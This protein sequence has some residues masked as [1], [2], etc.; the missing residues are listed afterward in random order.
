MPHPIEA[1]SL[2]EFETLLDAWTPVRRITQVHVHC[3]DHPR[4]AEFRGLASV[5]AMR[6][7]HQSIGM[8]DIAQH[9]TID[10]QGLIWTGRPFDVMPASVRGHNGTTAAGPFM[11]EMVGLFERKVDPFAGAQKNTA[12]AVVRAVLAKC[13][14][15]EN[16]VKFHREFLNTGKTCPGLDLDP[17]KFRTDIKA[18]LAN[19]T[20]SAF[21]VP[22]P[23]GLT[24]GAIV[25]TALTRSDLRPE[26]DYL[27][28]PEHAHAAEEQAV[29]TR[30]IEQGRLATDDGAGARGIEDEFRDLIG[31]AVNTSQGVLSG[32]G[33][34]QNTTADLDTLVRDHLTPQFDGD[35]FDHLLFYAHGGLVGETSAL[36]YARA[37]LP[38]WKSHRVY[39]IF[40]IW[41]SS[42]FQTIWKQPRGQRGLGD[43]WDKGVEVATQQLARPIWAEMKANARRCSEP[44]TRFGRP[45][46]LHELAQ[47]L[48]P[49]LSQHKKVKLHAVGH[50]TGPIVLAPFMRLF[51]DE[52]LAFESLNYLAP[53]IRIDDY[54][55][56]V[57]PIVDG[58]TV[59]RLRVFTMSDKAER[60]DN[61]A[62]IYRKSLLYYVR[63]ACEDRNDGR[64]LGLQKDLFADPSMRSAFGLADKRDLRAP[65]KYSVS[66]VRAIEF[67]QRD[68]D[69]A[70][71]QRTLATQHGGFDNDE[72]TL[73]SVL[74][75]VLGVA[76]LGFGG[77]RF[78]TS[79]DFARTLEGAD[80]A[81]AL[82]QP[83][84][85]EAQPSVDCVCCCCHGE[86]AKP[87][88]AFDR[89]DDGE[90]EPVDSG[91]Q[92][93]VDRAESPVTR[94]VAVCIGIDTYAGMPLSGCVNDS[95]AWQARL[96]RAGFSVTTL[97]NRD[98]TRSRMLE[99]L[100]S[101]VKD[102]RRGDQLVFQYAGHG[103]QVP[104][105]NGDE[106]DR[107]DEALVPVDYQRGE[108]LTDDDIYQVCAQLR[109]RPGVTLTFFMDCCNS[110]TNTRVAALPRPGLNQQVRF[111]KLPASVIREYE[112]VRRRDGARA[113]VP[114]AGEREPQPGVVSFAACLDH[115]FAFETDSHGD[116]TT[117]AMTVFDTTLAGGG[118]NQAFITA[119]L[120]AFGRDRRQNPTLLDPAP[121]MKQRRFLGG[122]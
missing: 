16:A 80:A 60:D 79:E 119:I 10:P 114:P 49:W 95:R 94:R 97:R 106:V 89:E 28:V 24:R 87:V 4:H 14:L 116:F 55:R 18:L 86:K 92:A 42:L 27:E 8:A 6:A 1:L 9:L 17:A 69:G 34:M 98:A 3:T 104:D 50:S 61:V 52:G 56:D 117:S 120:K 33:A 88:T 5:E 12:Y 75:N 25:R 115:E 93:S 101:L 31:H 76:A 32:K 84:D 21:D 122:R 83:D 63:D 99:A 13:G 11:V 110:G 39:P 26:P 41:E 23:S 102:S 58:R 48:L 103:T 2:S 59:K 7:F 100:T 109:E 29:L 113:T 85:G 22:V 73:R 78:P 112:A 74:A 35:G 30:L 47:R 20:L 57:A 44:T 118:S 37:M 15:D 105:L 46:G 67:S 81:R 96:E 62:Q 36:R 91:S 45:G 66:D 77:K 108:L 72:A 111:F 90:D 51:T 71:N 107:F 43:F 19:N 64:V 54:A 121:G 70:L 53:A 82:V 68:E 38:W 40:F 65:L